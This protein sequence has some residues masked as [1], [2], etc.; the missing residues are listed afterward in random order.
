[1]PF[2]P[3]E[4]VNP[5]SLS[6]DFGGVPEGIGGVGVTTHRAVVIEVVSCRKLHFRITAGPT[7]GFTAPMGTVV[8]ADPT[9]SILPV[10]R[11]PVWIG[12]TSTTAGAM[13]NGT[14]TIVCDELPLS[15]TITITA[16]TIPRPRSAVALVLDHSGSMAEDAGDGT[17]KVQ[18]LREAASIFVEAM[19]PGDGIGIARFDDTANRLMDIAD[20]G[21]LSGGGGRTTA[22]GHIGSNAL[23]PDG[24]T[25]I[26]GGVLE[27]KDTLDDG[28]TAATTPYN[29]LA[30]VVLTDGV[31][32]T[33]PMLS[34]VSSSITAN[35][36]AIGLGLPSNISVAALTALT[37]G[38]NGY[39]LVTGELT[40]DQRTRLTKYFLQV[41]AGHAP[42][43]VRRDRGRLRAG[44]VRAHAVPA[45]PAVRAPGTRWLRH[46]RQRPHDRGHRRGGGAPRVVA[47]PA[48]SA[49]RAGP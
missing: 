20:V 41:L 13:A 47:V 6:L 42:G 37:Q 28:Q 10:N 16:R 5:P 46:R 36:F 22:V 35:T 14:V 34:T 48:G 29:V 24:A 30:M 17:T 43:P 40:T 25:S 7:G 27:G 11:V 32:N 31:E 39:L 2:L 23:D 19:L 9:T 8:T 18:K 4:S 38:H 1:M 21:P 15:W 3:P 26:G 33:A 49:G 12:Y 44:R 45:G